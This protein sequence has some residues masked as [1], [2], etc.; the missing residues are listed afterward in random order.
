MLSKSFSNLDPDLKETSLLL[1]FWW[2][3]FHWLRGFQ[4]QRNIQL[5]LGMSVITW[6]FQ[7]SPDGGIYGFSAL[8]EKCNLSIPMPALPGKET[9]LLPSCSC[10]GQGWESCWLILGW[11]EWGWK[12]RHNISGKQAGLLWFFNLAH[13]RNLSIAAKS[14]FNHSSLERAPGAPFW[15]GKLNTTPFIPLF[16][17]KSPKRA[18]PLP[19]HWKIPF[20]PLHSHC[21]LTPLPKLKTIKFWET[22]TFSILSTCQALHPVSG[23]EIVWNLALINYEY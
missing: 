16:N 13:E 20:P 6:I 21:D 10:L 11:R 7:Q 15:R 18:A 19:F 4:R 14:W 8:V 5:I 1:R 9:T 2:I 23:P 17:P 3:N 22:L 12:N